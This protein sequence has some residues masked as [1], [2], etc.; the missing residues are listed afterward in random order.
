M[1]RRL[2]TFC[3]QSDVQRIADHF[4]WTYDEV[5]KEYVVARESADGFNVG[6]LRKVTEDVED[7]W[8][9][10]QRE[11]F[12]HFYCGIYKARP[13]DCGRSRRSAAKTST[14]NCPSAAST[15]SAI[16]S[17]RNGDLNDRRRC[18]DRRRRAI[19]G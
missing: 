8:R 1:L 14:W 11:R 19:T 4:G 17:N 2:R 12:G 10:P 7:K 6:W 16:R 15:S 18:R 9:V 5:M 13:H 3:Q